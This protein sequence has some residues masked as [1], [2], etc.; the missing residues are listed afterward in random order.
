MTIAQRLTVLVATSTLCLLLLSGMAYQQ[1]EKVYRAANYGNE[2]AIP[3]L[4]VLDRTT[5]AFYRLQNWT[6]THAV[7]HNAK[8]KIEIDKFIED[9]ST[10]IDQGLKEYEALL[11]N[12]EDKRHLE[13]NRRLLAEYR[14]IVTGALEMSWDYEQENAIKRIADN[15][16]LA[17]RVAK[18]LGAHKNFNEVLGKR[19]AEAAAQTKTQAAQLALILLAIAITISLAIGIT[20]VKRLTSRINGANRL[21][22]QVASGDL[23][24]RHAGEEGDDR[25]ALDEVGRLM[26]SLEKMR[27]DLAQTIAEVIGN[28]EHVAGA[29]NNLSNAASKVARSTDGQTAATASAAAAVEQMTVSIDHIASS[30]QAASHQAI[31]AGARAAN[32]GLTVG[33]ASSQVARVAEQVEITASQMQALSEQV[34]QIGSIT[35]VIR[36]V[37]EQ[38]NLLALNAAIE[39]A[40]AGEQG[41]GFAVVADEV[42]KLA[43]RTT[44]SV[45]EIGTVIGT[46]Q[47]GAAAVVKSMQGSRTDVGEVVLTAGAAS[48]SM[49]EIQSASD[50]VR[51]AIE[52]ISDA[53]REQKSTSTDLARNVESIA[54]LSD[55][56]AHAVEA[57]ADTAQRL[58]NLSESLK[59]S[60]ARFHI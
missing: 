15:A 30:A 58:V 59:N 40:R 41:R 34:K 19:E 32:S 57:V 46:I 28:A 60:V 55:D 21:A 20:T 43:E 45:Q 5:V 2:N 38:T 1:M 9:E 17:D 11:A 53:L 18:Q 48:A 10:R 54:R 50:T 39:A 49:N 22:A 35:V 47:S 6:L 4:Q 12:S 25:A 16:A 33:A 42:R 51:H 24:Q 27:A 31:E 56:N 37:A 23:R 13:E 29:T 26:Q 3:S 36:E 8:R 52:S 7:T 44:V 14:Q